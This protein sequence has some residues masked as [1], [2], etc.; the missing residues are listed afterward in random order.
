M[1][2]ELNRKLTNFVKEKN[3]IFVFDY[4]QF[5]LKHGRKIFLIIN[6][7]YLEIF[8]IAFDF[9]PYFANELVGISNNVRS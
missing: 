3:S 7:F 4:I 6:N 5:I 9:I 2:Y 8:K 1:I